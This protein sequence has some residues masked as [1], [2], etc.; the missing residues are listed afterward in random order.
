MRFDNL[1]I[2]LQ[3]MENLV[4]Q[5]MESRGWKI[6][7]IDVQSISID[8]DYSIV[9]E[10]NCEDLQEITYYDHKITYT[11]PKEITVDVEKFLND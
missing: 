11:I 1:V 5:E 9:L 10:L 8:G 2:I 6:S 7:E 3:K 4:K